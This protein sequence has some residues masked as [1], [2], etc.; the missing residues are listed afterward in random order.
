[1][2]AWHGGGDDAGVL[3]L[4]FDPVQLE[5]DIMDGPDPSGGVET[6]ALIQTATDRRVDPLELPAGKENR[7]WWADA[8]FAGEPPLGSRHWLL[9]DA[10]G[11]AEVLAR[12]EEYQAEALSPL[13]ADGRITEATPVSE[14]V[15]THVSIAG[16]LVLPSGA[17]V[18]LGPLPLN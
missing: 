17:V 2:L 3:A 5:G 1:L 18:Q 6:E 10:L 7:G 11:T 4:R 13:I 14:L 12:A 16:A 8:F 9:E 15:A